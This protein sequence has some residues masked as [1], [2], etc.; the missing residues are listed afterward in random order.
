MQPCRQMKM[1]LKLAASAHLQNFTEDGDVI[2]VDV[3]A[4]IL[5]K[6]FAIEEVV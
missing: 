3:D 1:I 6:L 5:A 4:F 2:M